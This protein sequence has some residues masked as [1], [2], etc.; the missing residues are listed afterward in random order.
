[1]D[2]NK[3]FLELKRRNVIK[4][5]LAYLAIAWILLQVFSILLP[6]VDA[7]K[8]VLKTL[9]LIMLI[10]FP[11][12]LGF[13][14]KYQITQDGLKKIE[15]TN[16]YFSKNIKLVAGILLLAIITMIVFSLFKQYNIKDNIEKN[17]TNKTIN[18][19]LI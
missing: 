18:D 13:S 12:W 6:M 14:W 19:S 1:M 7:P 4:A 16:S 15:N 9:T 8:W 2:L 10:G 5:A 11:F 17:I 3:F